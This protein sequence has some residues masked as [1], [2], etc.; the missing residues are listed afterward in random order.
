[1]TAEKKEQLVKKLENIWFYYKWY[2]II[3]ATSYYGIIVN[4]YDLIHPIG[5]K[6]YEI[7]KSYNRS[8]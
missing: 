4:I 6:T 3:L 7:C 8:I 2:I 5:C 1:M